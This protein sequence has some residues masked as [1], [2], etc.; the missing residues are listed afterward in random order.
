ME[1]ILEPWA[2]TLFGLTF[3]L[4]NIF[5]T[6]ASFLFIRSFCQVREK[7]TGLYMILILTLSDFAFLVLNIVT[8]LLEKNEQWDNILYYTTGI[9]FCFS[10]YWAAAI[11]VF[12]YK[13][14]T[15][16]RSFNSGGFLKKA[17]LAVGALT[18]YCPLL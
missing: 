11:A 2:A 7:S 9:I 12:S 3:W 17:L 6:I 8:I 10:L 1:S 14:L 13:I 16:T 5:I 4:T 15:A 18:M